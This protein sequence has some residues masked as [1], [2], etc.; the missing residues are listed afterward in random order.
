MNAIHV[1]IHAALHE[2][3]AI[4]YHLGRLQE[5]LRRTVALARAASIGALLLL[6]AALAGCRTELADATATLSCLRDGEWQAL[7]VVFYG[8]PALA[9]AAS[10]PYRAEDGL[11][12]YLDIEATRAPR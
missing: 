9:K 10:G 6:V 11:L 12:C 3:R 8:D 2:K 7:H 4:E 5:E 1:R